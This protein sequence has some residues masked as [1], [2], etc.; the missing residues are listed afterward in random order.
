MGI[1]NKLCC[2][3]CQ[4]KLAIDYYEGEMG[5]ISCLECKSRYPI[6][7]NIPRFLSGKLLKNCYFYYFD[8]INDNKILKEF[9]LAES[10]SENLSN[11]KIVKLK[12]DTQKQFGYEWHIWKKLPDFAENHFLEVMGKPEEFFRGKT[13]WDPAVGMGRDLFNAAKAVGEGGMM[14][15]SDLS[16]AIDMAYERCK[17][18]K[19]VIIVQADLYSNFIHNN[20]LDFAYMIGLIQHLTEP[21]AGMEHVYSKIKKNGYFVG[22]IYTKPDHML[23][24]FLVSFIHFVRIFTLHMSL[25][26]VL[27]ISRLCALPAYM[28]FKLPKFILNKFKYIRDMD[29]LYPTHETQKRSPDLDLLAHNWFDHFTPPV[30]GFYSDKEI[31]NMLQNIKLSNFTLKYGIYSG[32]KTE[33]TEDSFLSMSEEFKNKID[34]FSSYPERMGYSEEH[35]KKW[36]RK[37]NSKSDGSQFAVCDFNEEILSFFG[38]GHGKSIFLFSPSLTEVNLFSRVFSRVYFIALPQIDGKLPDN[39]VQLGYD[40]NFEIT[41]SDEI[42]KNIFVDYFFSNHVIEHIHPDDFKKHLELVYK[43]LK[44]GG[45][46]LVICPSKIRILKDENSQKSEKI[47]AANHHIGRY[48][49]NGIN[50]LS[51]EIGFEKT[52]CPVINPYVFNFWTKYEFCPSE[53]IIERVYKFVPEKVLSALGL[54]SLYIKIQK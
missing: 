36:Y 47:I 48:E 20:S 51:K 11:N 22:T 4:G 34:K 26:L 17:N 28:F 13:G 9:F 43:F 38:K 45:Q 50:Q 49:Y 2:I 39:A 54:N 40:G 31:M 29:E 19:N 6:I 52:Y 30:I 18:M 44:K 41:G 42:G 46:Y 1:E 7:K 21:Q 14:I 5:L 15:G 10:I 32:F 8:L 3:K 12:S 23:G 37:L 35:F 16:F 53:K 24:K 25:P 27:F 33:N